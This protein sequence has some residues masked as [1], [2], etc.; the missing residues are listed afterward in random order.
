MGGCSAVNAG[1]TVRGAVG[2]YD[3]WAALGNAGW[4]FAASSAMTL[5]RDNLTVAPSRSRRGLPKRKS[6]TLAIGEA[7]TNLDGG[8]MYGILLEEGVKSST[9]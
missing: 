2:D 6:L 3:E 5:R 9:G 1:V 8:G 4:S 7:Q